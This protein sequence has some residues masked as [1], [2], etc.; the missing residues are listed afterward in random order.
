MALILSMSALTACGGGG[1]GSTE[2][3]TPQPTTPNVQEQTHNSVK[4]KTVKADLLLLAVTDFDDPVD[5]D[6]GRFQVEAG[7]NC[8]STYSFSDGG[9]IDFEISS[10]SQPTNAND[11]DGFLKVIRSDD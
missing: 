9:D 2:P 1:G 11:P 10:D 5:G 6:S 7:E 3:T 8:V 4:T